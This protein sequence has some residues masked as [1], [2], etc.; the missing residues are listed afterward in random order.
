MCTN[1]CWWCSAL[2]GWFL[3]PFLCYKVI[4]CGPAFALLCCKPCWSRTYWEWV[5]FAGYRGLA[6][7]TEIWIIFQSLVGGGL[8][9]V[10]GGHLSLQS[11]VSV[12][13][14]YRVGGSKLQ[15]RPL[16]QTGHSLVGMNS[17]CFWGVFR[18][19]VLILSLM[20]GEEHCFCLTEFSGE[21]NNLIAIIKGLSHERLRGVRDWLLFIGVFIEELTAY[22]ALTGDE[23]K[24]ITLGTVFALP[25]G[26]LLYV[27]CFDFHRIHCKEGSEI[28]DYIIS[29]SRKI[30]IKISKYFDWMRWWN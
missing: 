3:F 25:K 24:A 15:L 9:C 6:K 1:R 12:F 22:T 13:A 29:Y 21:S 16:S 28:K 20:S 26:E 11:R 17:S 19:R 27:I 4:I 23:L 30:S 14:S 2:G 10:L 7:I 5:I 18:S 8:P